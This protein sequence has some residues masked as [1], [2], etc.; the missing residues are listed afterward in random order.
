MNHGKRDKLP[1]IDVVPIDDVEI[2]TLRRFV[3]RIPDEEIERFFEEKC[4]FPDKKVERY[5]AFLLYIALELLDGLG[6]YLRFRHGKLVTNLSGITS[7][8]R[9]HNFSF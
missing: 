4:F 2:E 8:T 5:K 7:E 3:K 6:I 9:I 1:R